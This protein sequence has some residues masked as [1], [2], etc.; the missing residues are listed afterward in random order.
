MNGK[1]FFTLLNLMIQAPNEPVVG[2][3]FF[4]YTFPAAAEEAP[5]VWAFHGKPKPNDDG[6][7]VLLTFRILQRQP[8][9]AVLHVHGVGNLGDYLQ[10]FNSFADRD[11]E[12][13]GVNQ[14]GEGLALC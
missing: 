14:S 1:T 3:L 13:M 7:G 10:V 4:I 2:F 12:L 11:L 5:A 6:P 8:E 9:D